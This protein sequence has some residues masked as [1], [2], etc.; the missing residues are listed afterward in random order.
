MFQKW[1]DKRK[2]DIVYLFQYWN[3]AQEHIFDWRLY[4]VNQNRFEGAIRAA[5]FTQERLAEKMGI[6]ANTLTTKKKKGTFT[7]AQVELVCSILGIDDPKDKC[8]IF[9]QT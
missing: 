1:I 3:K 8:E 9:L 2:Q 7:I 4:T 6:S 5:G